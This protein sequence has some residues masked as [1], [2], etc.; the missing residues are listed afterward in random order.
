MPDEK[1]R[2]LNWMTR[3]TFVARSEVRATCCSANCPRKRKRAEPAA[4][5]DLP[6]AAWARAGT[7]DSRKLKVDVSRRG[8]HRGRPFCFCLSPICDS[9]WGERHAAKALRTRRPRPCG[10]T[11]A[12]GAPRC[13]VDIVAS[14]HDVF[15]TRFR[16]CDTTSLLGYLAPAE[17]ARGRRVQNKKEAAARQ[18]LP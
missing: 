4:T 10:Q 9:P 17:L 5:P 16:S 3:Y 7:E 12:S 2:T 14:G 13:Q 18:L 6:E 11:A 1:P 8:G 15:L